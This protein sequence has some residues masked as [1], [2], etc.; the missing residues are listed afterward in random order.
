ME[1]RREMYMAAVRLALVLSL[2]AVILA[3]AAQSFGE[4]SPARFVSA[5]AV[6]GFVAS[7]MVTG[8]VVRAAHV[9]SGR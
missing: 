3:V 9:V 6:V 2:G 1:I 7:W 8:R 5:V 4:L